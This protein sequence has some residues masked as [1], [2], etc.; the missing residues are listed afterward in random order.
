[1]I[2]T[3]TGEAVEGDAQHSYHNIQWAGFEECYLRDN[4]A[5][6]KD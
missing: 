2:A 3:E 6:A 5:P 4:Y 1:M